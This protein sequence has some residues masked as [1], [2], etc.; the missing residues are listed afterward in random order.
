MG[1]MEFCEIRDGALVPTY[2][3]QLAPIRCDWCQEAESSLLGFG[4]LWV[5]PDCFGEAE[6]EWTRTGGGR[7]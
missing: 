2:K 6:S 7:R 3:G 1:L 5:C 4:A